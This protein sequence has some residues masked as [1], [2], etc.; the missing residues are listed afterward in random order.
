MGL[1]SFGAIGFSSLS[2]FDVQALVNQVLFSAKAPVRLL[3]GQQLQLNAQS[4][5]LSDI[6]S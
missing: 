4:S 1:F 2:G 5:A 3:E 6:N